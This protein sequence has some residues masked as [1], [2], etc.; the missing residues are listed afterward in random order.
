MGRSSGGLLEVWVWGVELTLAG[1]EGNYD[2]ERRVS[3]DLNLTSI[4]SI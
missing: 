2:V 4:P 1:C 3:I